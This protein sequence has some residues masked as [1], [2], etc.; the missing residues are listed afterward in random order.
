MMERTQI[1]LT[2]EEREALRRIAERNNLSQSEIIRQAIDR[3]ISEDLSDAEAEAILERT[4]GIWAGREDVP[5]I[6]ALRREID[7][8]VDAVWT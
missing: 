3:Y 1:Y 6:E 5:D 2:R 4:F 8:R 7:E